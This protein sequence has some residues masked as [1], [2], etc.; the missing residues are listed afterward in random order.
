VEGD[1]ISL[2]KGKTQIDAV[3]L[4]GTEGQ[5]LKVGSWVLISGKGDV[6]ASRI[7]MLVRYSLEKVK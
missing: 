2:G 4:Y 7:W 6:L 1:A 5:N 3:L